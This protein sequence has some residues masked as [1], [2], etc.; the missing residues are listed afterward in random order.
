MIVVDGRTD[1]EKLRELLLEPEQTHLDFKTTVDLTNTKDKLEF[2]KDAVSMA[3][4]PPGGYIIVGAHE[5]GALA[6]RP[7][8][9]RTARSSTGHGWAT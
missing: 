3:N 6:L 2:V 7:A 8:R 5:G 9:F 1:V 4:R